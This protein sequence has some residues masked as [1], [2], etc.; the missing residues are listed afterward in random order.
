MLISESEHERHRLVFGPTHVCVLKCNVV[1][2]R[3][4]DGNIMKTTNN[5]LKFVVTLISI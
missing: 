2:G 5:K 1:D 3:Y 4:S